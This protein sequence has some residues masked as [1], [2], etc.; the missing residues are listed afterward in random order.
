MES[1]EIVLGRRTNHFVRIF[2]SQFGFSEE[3]AERFVSMAG[4][5]L[6]ESYKFLARDLDPRG[7][8]CPANV[9]DLLST[10]HASR[11]ASSLGIPASEVWTGLRVFVP[12]VLQLADGRYPSEAA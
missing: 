2:M 11:I 8:S 5:D 7:L 1:L 3:R 6:M 10:I 9:R 4:S 12:S